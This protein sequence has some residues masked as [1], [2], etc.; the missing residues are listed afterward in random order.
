MAAIGRPIG[1]APA[2]KVRALALNTARLDEPEATA[3]S[4]ELSD[5]LGLVCR[6]P[7]R[8]GAE[9]LLE[10]LLPHDP[11]VMRREGERG[12]SNPRIAAPQAAALTTWR[13]PPRR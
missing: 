8:H 13:R 3:L 4:R 7:I 2:P 12:D 11:K 9:D 6:D 5:Q 10:A 1:S